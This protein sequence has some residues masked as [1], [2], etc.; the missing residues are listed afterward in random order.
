VAASTELIGHLWEEHG[1]LQYW[2]IWEII[3]GTRGD[4]QFHRGMVD[5]PLATEPTLTAHCSLASQLAMST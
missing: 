1:D 2:A 5:H 3:I 4:A